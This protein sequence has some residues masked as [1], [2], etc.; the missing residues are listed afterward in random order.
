M[1]TKYNK[2]LLLCEIENGLRLAAHVFAESGRLLDMQV[3]VNEY[4]VLEN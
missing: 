3:I 4:R 1:K 2:A